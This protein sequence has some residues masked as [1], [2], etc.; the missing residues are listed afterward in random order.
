[1]VPGGAVL[2]SRFAPAIKVA[3]S[4]AADGLPIFFFFRRN[5][6]SRATPPAVR[7]VAMLVPP[8]KQYFS[9]R[10]YFIQPNTSGG[11]CVDRVERM[12]VPG[13]TTSGFILPSLV[14]PRPLNG[15]TW[16]GSFARGS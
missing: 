7:G 6:R 14:G 10:W 11:N 12:N 2:G 3:F 15:T 9:L 5:S 4:R 13:A 8:S 16:L 1:M